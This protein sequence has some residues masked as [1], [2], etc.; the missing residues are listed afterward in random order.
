MMGK[1]PDDVV[2]KYFKLIGTPMLIPQWA[3]G[4]NQCRWGYTTLAEA[5]AVVDGYKTNN[6]PLDVQWSDIDYLNKY[7]NFEY[8][9]VNYDG[10][11]T[12]IDDL[13][14][15]NKKYIPIIDAGLA[16][17]PTAQGKDAYEAYNSGITKN[18]FMKINGSVLIGSVWPGDSV[19]PDY[20]AK[21][22][23]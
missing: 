4:W 16:A 7:R 23:S 8:D 12:F 2:K 21:N 18:V 14:K 19:F 13:H 20:F 10:L 3:L 11:D 1:G 22:T 6:L 5:K 9:S 17:R 15:A